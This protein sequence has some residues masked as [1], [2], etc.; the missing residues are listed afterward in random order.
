[1]DWNPLIGSALGLGFLAGIRLY[2]T[3]FILGIVIYFGWIPVTAEHEHWSVL[4]HPAILGV[5][6][7]A[8]LVEFIADK[9]PLVDSLWDSFHT[10]IRPV[11]AG[12]LATTIVG[13]ADPVVKT[14]LVILCGGV[15]L[16]SHGSKA[17]TRL[18]INHSPEPVTN[19]SA[20]FLEDALVPLGIWLAIAH[21]F[22]TLALVVSFLVAFAWLAAKVFR[23]MRT[24]IAGLY[25]RLG[26]THHT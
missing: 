23:A 13:D 7:V 10:F 11:G 26:L 12:L 2:A 17:A 9:I 1:M 16:A 22:V 21:P 14:A 6:G 20:S 19:I 4:A 5:S 25:A 15:A 18:A 24:L 3:V 8:L